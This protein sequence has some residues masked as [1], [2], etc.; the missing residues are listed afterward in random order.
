MA[1]E[2]TNRSE[3]TTDAEFKEW[4]G[5]YETLY[6]QTEKLKKDFE[7]V[8]RYTK[9]TSL[10]QS[11]ICMHFSKFYDSSTAGNMYNAVNRNTENVRLVDA[12]RLRFE[13]DLNNNIITP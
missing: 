1:L 4:K 9:E 12:E 6:K 5:H 2:K 10:A 8:I 7:E 3:K 11:E 13:E